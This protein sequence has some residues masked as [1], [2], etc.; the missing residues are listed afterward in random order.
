MKKGE[1][2]TR[3]KK[4]SNRYDYASHY[5]RAGR[6]DVEEIRQLWQDSSETA[7]TKK[8]WPLVRLD[9]GIRVSLESDRYANFFVHGT[10]CAKC[11][12]EGKY[13]WL[14][15]PKRSKTKSHEWH[16]NLYGVTEDGQEMMLTKDHI[17][18]KSKGG[19][20]HISN[21]QVLCERCN[22]AKAN[23]VE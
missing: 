11:G 14:E 16:L 21:Y 9:K 1:P 5:V 23:R 20:N 12:L 4:P 22:L 13:F 15:T 18:P 3:K 8:A 6:H 10:R 19:H 7:S 17:I 2:M